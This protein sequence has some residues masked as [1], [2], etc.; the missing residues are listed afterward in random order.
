MEFT[1]I[2][3]TEI[4]VIL[5]VAS[6]VQ[7]SIG[8][9]AGMFAIPLLMLVGVSLPQAIAIALIASMLQNIAGLVELRREID[10]K[11]SLFPLSLRLVALPF[12]VLTLSWIDG[13]DENITKQIMGVVILSIIGLQWIAKI[14]P[15]EKVHV[16]WTFAAFFGSGYL[17]G[18]CGMGGPPMVLWVMAHDW[19][20]R[21]TRAF[22]FTMF[23]SSI[24]P[25]VVLMWMEFGNEILW[26]MATALLTTPICLIG[27]YAGVKSGDLL[28]E[29]T[30][31][32]TIYTVLIGICINLIAGPT[33]W[34]LIRN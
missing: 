32:I 8:F 30:M 12:G 24:L 9:G 7:G 16:G 11:T 33:L 26:L 34:S 21:R 23:I 1:S 5:F 3:L 10:L 18:F 6:F 20:S 28:A 27:S 14:K 19:N 22:L 29:K 15:Q 25:H 4:G 31:R 2:Q 17:V 13:F